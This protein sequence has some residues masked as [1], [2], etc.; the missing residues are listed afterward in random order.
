MVIFILPMVSSLMVD[1]NSTVHIFVTDPDI[2]IEITNLII[3]AYPVC[4]CK[5]ACICKIGIEA[6]TWTCKI[7]TVKAAY[8]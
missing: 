4:I 8:L 6:Q 5:N 2:D 1:Y 3:R 7:N